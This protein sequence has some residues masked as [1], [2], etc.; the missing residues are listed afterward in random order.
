MSDAFNAAL[1]RIP[2]SLVSTD[3]MRVL[4]DTVQDCLP[5]GGALLEVGVY[6]GGSAVLLRHAAPDARLILCDTF[7]GHPS[8]DAVHDDPEHY[9]GRYADTSAEAVAWLFHGHPNPPELIV[10]A[11]PGSATT[12]P[13]LCFAHV[14]VDLYQS[15][16]Q[17]LQHV[18]P[19]L[20]PGGAVVC[21]DYGFPCC[22][23]AMAAVQAF[24]QQQT[25]AALEELPTLQAR[26]RKAPRAR[27]DTPR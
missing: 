3:R 15:T 16:L 14:D 13:T 27:P 21:D 23:G 9:P 2:Y 7:A 10:G 19:L 8:V 6:Q 11:F 25:D 24:V 1:T 20:Q 18:W 26:L 22:P 17:S 12:L 5:L 4:W